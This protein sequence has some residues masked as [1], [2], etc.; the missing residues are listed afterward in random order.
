MLGSG[1]S[2]ASSRYSQFLTEA[3]LA[4][5]KKKAKMLLPASSVTA[6]HVITQCNTGRMPDGSAAVSVK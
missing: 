3:A 4:E 1:V 6:G 5:A 2:V